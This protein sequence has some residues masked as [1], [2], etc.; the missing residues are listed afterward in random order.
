M[1]LAELLKKELSQEALRLQK[2]LE[3]YYSN[4]KLERVL[5]QLEA[6]K[7]NLIQTLTTFVKQ[8]PK[9]TEENLL[10]LLAQGAKVAVTNKFRTIFAGPIVVTFYNEILSRDKNGHDLLWLDEDKT[11]RLILIAIPENEEK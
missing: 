7:E 8:L 9:G 2:E 4:K 11:Y 1:E 5:K 10:T 6:K 3:D